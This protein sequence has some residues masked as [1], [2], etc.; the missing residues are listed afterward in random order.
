MRLC[1]LPFLT[2]EVAVFLGLKPPTKGAVS[3]TRLSER[4]LRA[5]LVGA[6]MEGMHF[7]EALM[8]SL[9]WK[10]VGHHVDFAP[11]G[12]GEL[13]EMCL[14]GLVDPSY[15][16]SGPHS[17][18]LEEAQLSSVRCLVGLTATWPWQPDHLPSAHR[19]GWWGWA[20]AFDPTRNQFRQKNPNEHLDGSHTSLHQKG[21]EN[22]KKGRLHGEDPIMKIFAEMTNKLISVVLR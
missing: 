3:N 17:D 12:P 2:K 7:F 8:S 4:N 9:K 14:D 15:E 21:S 10:V 11:G 16:V 22:L 13:C 1:N 5:N 19:G 18:I 20:F 6:P